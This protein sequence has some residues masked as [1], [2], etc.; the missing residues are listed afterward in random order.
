MTES[1]NCFCLKF[2]FSYLGTFFL[3]LDII[4]L[5]LT[6][7]PLS[8]SLFLVFSFSSLIDIRNRDLLK[9][10]TTE[11]VQRENVYTLALVQRRDPLGSTIL[12][13]LAAIHL[14]FL[15]QHFPLPSIC[16]T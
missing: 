7:L 9:S 5:Y 3:I 14:S 4:F 12:L 10:H 6:P 15:F 8:L 2:I 13:F 16:S 11:V 1:L